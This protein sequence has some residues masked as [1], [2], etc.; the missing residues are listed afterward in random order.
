[1]RC[2]HL[3][4]LALPLALAL[5][6]GSA[7]PPPAAEASNNVVGPSGKAMD[8]KPLATV[9]AP[10]ADAGEKKAVE[11][12]PPPPP[13]GGG[14]KAP[15]R[16]IATDAPIVSKITQDDILALV[17][18]NGDTFYK[19]QSIGAGASKSWRAIVTIKAT[20]SPTGA[21][22][23]IELMTS[24]SKNPRVDS[25][26]LD[27]FKKLTFARPAGS[28]ATVFTFPMSFEPMQQVQ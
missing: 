19:C 11:S 1:M 16:A 8:D 24:T 26:V 12:P 20:V 4:V 2:R 10:A 18:K 21:V 17:N 5:G 7:P 9:N 14:S 3:L 22:S 25:C 27:A 15:G 6:C 13:P 23:A 28:G